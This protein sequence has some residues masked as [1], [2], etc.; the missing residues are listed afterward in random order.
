MNPANLD[1]YQNCVE[2]CAA[3]DYG[4]PQAVKVH[5][6]AVQKMYEIV[7]QAVREG[8]E[9]IKILATLLD[10]PLAARWLAFQLLE[11]ANVDTEVENKCLS[12][13]NGMANAGSADSYGAGVWLEKWKQNRN[14]A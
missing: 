3:T 8:A 10:H 11:K 4:D 1:E 6:R 5:N 14:R 13:I 12:I 2:K 7:E 9:A